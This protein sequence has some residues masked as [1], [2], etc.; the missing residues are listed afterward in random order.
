VL[1]A[2]LSFT[3]G[4]IRDDVRDIRSS[5]REMNVVNTRLTDQI[6]LLR[7][8]YV[9]ISSRVE[10]LNKAIDYLMKWLSDLFRNSP[11]PRS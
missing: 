9:A 6:Q 11:P 2:V 5:I 7:T 3:I 10:N 1:W 4:G 8:D